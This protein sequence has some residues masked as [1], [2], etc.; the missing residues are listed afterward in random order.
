MFN[1]F[2]GVIVAFTGLAGS[3]LLYQQ[4]KILQTQEQWFIKQ[5]SSADNQSIEATRSSLFNHAI[6]I[7]NQLIQNPQLI[8]FFYEG[9]EIDKNLSESDKAKCIIISEMICDM[10][11]H[12]SGSNMNEKTKN[13]WRN[14]ANDM[15]KNSPVLKD[16]LDTNKSWYVSIHEWINK[17]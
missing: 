13:G 14:Y 8:P 10:L 5:T 7:Q 4:N 9:K 16:F 11:D 15:I 6:E 12:A 17:Q 3:A 2:V 1:I